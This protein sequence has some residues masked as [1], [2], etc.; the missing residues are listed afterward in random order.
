MAAFLFGTFY[1]AMALASL[2]VEW[3]FVGSGLVPHERVA[4]VVEAS[5]RL[6]YTTVL[7]IAFGL[8]AI[9]LVVHFL[10]TGGP[11]MPREMER[12]PRGGSRCTT[13]AQPIEKHA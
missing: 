10:R 7:N 6:N 5:V 12:R 3:I 2:A 13:G 11:G 9:A 4:R 8:L 1:L